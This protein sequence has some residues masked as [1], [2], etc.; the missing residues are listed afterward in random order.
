MCFFLQS[1]SHLRCFS[2]HKSQ[3]VTRGVESAGD[4][5]AMIT[6]DRSTLAL[7]PNSALA[8]AVAGFNDAAGV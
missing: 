1:D 6:G 4:I 2:V 8:V 7:G 5:S 3:H